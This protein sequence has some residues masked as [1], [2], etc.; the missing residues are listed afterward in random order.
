MK[1]PFKKPKAGDKVE[2][3]MEE[4]N[5]EG[6]LLESHDKGILLLKLDSGY[7]IGFKIVESAPL[8][9]SSYHAEKARK[10]FK[11]GVNYA[12]NNYGASFPSNKCNQGSY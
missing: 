10:L 3:V 9:R 2:L 4:G 7:N 12:N 8:V 1:K 6:I 5:K 11:K